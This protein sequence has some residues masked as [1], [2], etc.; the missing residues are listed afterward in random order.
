M[1][2]RKRHGIQ[3]VCTLLQNANIKGFFTGQIYKGPVKNVCVPG[4]NCYS[5]PGAVG[6]CPIGSLQHS[7]SARRFRIP[8]YV[9][10]LLIFFG[11]L[12][13]RA[14]CGFICPMGFL[15]DLL[16]KIPFP[17]K[18]R[19]FKG[20]RILRKLKYA[21][22]IMMCIVLPLF[23]KLTPF[24][25]KYICPSGTIAGI[26]LAFS[27]TELFS[28]MGSRF[29]WKVCVLSCI[30]LL[31]VLIYRPFCK[32]LCPLGAIY[33]PMNKISVLQLEVDSAKCLKCGACYRACGMNVDPVRTP[34]HTEC[35]RC[36]RCIASC[37]AGAIS[38]TNVFHKEKKAEPRET[39]S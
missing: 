34:D 32:Y 33:A 28:L 30:V 2:D 10:G 15:Q 12:L 24:F 26:L 29:V 39:C 1:V 22:L 6:A 5:C 27:N 18:I 21:V 9:V 3:A 14:V 19:T 8:Y 16:N 17:K 11:A 37:P 7:L 31:S 36:G 13:G 38:Y 25:C 4:L 20:D 35:I 23:V